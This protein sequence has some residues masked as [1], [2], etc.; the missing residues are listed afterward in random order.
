MVVHHQTWPTFA[1]TNLL[2][3]NSIHSRTEM[4]TFFEKNRQDVVGGPSISF[5]RKAVV[6]LLFE[7]QQTYA[8]LLLAL[9]IA[10]DTTTRCVNPCQPVFIRVGIPIQRRKDLRLNK[11]KPAALKI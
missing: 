11:T 6:K 4:K 2:L 8:K 10:T 1:Y 5:G 7:N 9:T 3:Q